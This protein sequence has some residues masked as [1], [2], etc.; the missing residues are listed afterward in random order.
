[1]LNTAIQRQYMEQNK[2]FFSHLHHQWAYK[3]FFQLI[4]LTTLNWQ[5]GIKMWHY[6][7]KMLLSV[8]Y[9]AEKLSK[10]KIFYASY[11]LQVCLFS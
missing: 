11:F 1:M 7:F 6:H 2:L 10:I 4:L 5:I 8:I 3:V 9:S